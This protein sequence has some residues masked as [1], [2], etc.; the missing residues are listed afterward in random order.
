MKRP[1]VSLAAA[2]EI[3]ERLAIEA[4]GVDAHARRRGLVRRLRRA[5]TR[6]T[7]T[8]C[9]RPRRTASGSK[10]VLSRRAGRLRDAGRDLAAH[11]IN[12]VLTTRRRAAVPAR[13]R[14]R[15]RARSGAGGRARR[16]RAEVCRAAGCAHDRRRDRRSCRA[17]TASRSSTS[18][19]RASGI[20]ERDQLIDGSAL[21]GGRRRARSPLRRACT[22]TASRSCAGARRRGRRFDAGPC[23][24]RRTGSTSTRCA[25]SG[26]GGREGARPRHRRRHPRQPDA[27][28]ARGHRRRDRLGRVGA[29]GGLRLARPSTVSR[30][31]SSAGS[32]TSASACA[33]SFRPATR[34]AEP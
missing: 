17:S 30:R 6:S 19:A 3:V 4:V 29:A 33:P 14:R 22:R 24:S 23:C 10:L 18:P 31:R 21:R 11:C 34:A 15:A 27:R 8:G 25:G 20:V 9:S 1:G 13:L 2:E 16:G 26:A 5:L 7:R 32:S 28:P 12:D